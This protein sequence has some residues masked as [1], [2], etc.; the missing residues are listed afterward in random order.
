MALQGSQGCSRRAGYSSCP[1][2]GGETPAGSEGAH[3]H[4]AQRG[5]S[6][7]PPPGCPSRTAHPA[8]PAGWSPAIP[9]AAREQGAVGTQGTGA[10]ALL[11]HHFA[12]LIFPW[13]RCAVCWKPVKNHD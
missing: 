2:E 5:G 7:L 6:G 8:V 13:C 10:G 12:V 9:R 3:V 4:R 11:S 1:K